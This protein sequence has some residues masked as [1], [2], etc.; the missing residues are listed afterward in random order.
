MCTEKYHN[1]NM[2]LIDNANL[3]FLRAEQKL[4]KYLRK[5]IMTFPEELREDVMDERRRK[6]VVK[7]QRKNQDAEVKDIKGMLSEPLMLAQRVECFTVCL[8][9]RDEYLMHIEDCKKVKDVF[10]TLPQ[11]EVDVYKYQGERDTL[12]EFFMKTENREIVA[13]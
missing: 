10:M 4:N 8:K 13:Y 9:V 6:D 1:F 11:V 7:H 3:K 5:T 2:Q 12:K